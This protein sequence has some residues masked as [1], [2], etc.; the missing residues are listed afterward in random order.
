MAGILPCQEGSVAFQGREITGD[1]IA[2][3]KANGIGF[4]AQDR[5]RHGLILDFSVE[6]NLLLGMQRRSEYISR[7]FLQDGGKIQAMA[8]ERIRDFDIR[9]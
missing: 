5:H 1:S 3:R 2:E 9:P 7:R 6:E 4:I 8:E